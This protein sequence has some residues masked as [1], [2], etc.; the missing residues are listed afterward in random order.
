MTNKADLTDAVYGAKR[1]DILFNF[2]RQSL[3]HLCKVALCFVFVGFREEDNSVGVLQRNLVF[4]Q[5]QIVS[6]S[7]KT[8]HHYEE[9]NSDKVRLCGGGFC[10]RISIGL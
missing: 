5:T 8:M 2:A 1:Q 4:H 9:M 10:L 7:L 3:A 6:V